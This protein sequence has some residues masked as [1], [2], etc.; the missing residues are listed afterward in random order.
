MY[1]DVSK[2]KRMFIIQT[3]DLSQVIY[4]LLA[5]VC[6]D[7]F[8]FQVELM[9]EKKSEAA[10]P[11]FEPGSSRIQIEDATATPLRFVDFRMVKSSE[12]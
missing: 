12:D 7:S 10:S 5:D 11:S 6:P 8:F 9:S 2:V 1:M 4:I 3:I